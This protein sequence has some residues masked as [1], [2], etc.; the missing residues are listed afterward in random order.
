MR[1]SMTAALVLVA[2]WTGAVHA[3][4][5]EWAVPH[6]EEFLLAY[7]EQAGRL[8]DCG[9]GEGPGR[10]DVAVKVETFVEWRHSG[11]GA[12]LTGA[13]D[14]YGDELL[15]RAEAAFAQGR[16]EGCT[17]PGASGWRGLLNSSDAG[18]AEVLALAPP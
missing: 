17:F 4:P 18:L 5:T 8:A 15:R 16:I 3:S 9:P 14:E 13:R 10:E 6:G 1:P 2:A 7:A 11:W 12:W